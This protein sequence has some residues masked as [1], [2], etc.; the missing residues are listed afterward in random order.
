M[1]STL[2]RGAF[3]VSIDTEMAWGEAH[4]RG[5]ASS[6]TGRT[7]DGEREVIAQ[8]L[9]TFA[10]Y[11]ISA[12]WAVVGHLFLDQCHDEGSGPHPELVR[13]DY[14][15]LDGD[16]FDVDPCSSLADDPS[17]YGPDIVN[18]ILACPTPQEIGSH[19]FSHLIVDDPA[20][21][22]EVFTS[23][24]AAATKAAAP[25]GI[26]LRSFVY[27]RNSIAQVERLAE[28]GYRSY[29]GKRLSPSFAGRPAWQQRALRFVD[30]VYP[31]AGSVARP[32]RHASGVWNIPQS[33]YLL[34]PPA[35][36]RR[37]RPTRPTYGPIARLRQ[38]ARHQSVFHM[39]FHPH[40]IVGRSGALQTLERI[41]AAAARLR[42]AGRLDVVTMGDLGARL[43]AAHRSAEP[44]VDST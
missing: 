3:V 18:A 29:R 31:L 40:N 8:I 15:W 25:W 10:R 28:H 43:E 19:S 32:V 39:W 24:L 7:Y 30:R 42:D 16:W 4:H 37:W 17:Y 13:A 26:E 14:T 1:T 12:T 21:T 23:E 2:E 27:P 35:P 22:P 5:T 34:A 41:C 33:C 44:S 38:A 36:T 11:E 9:A 6:S 20:C